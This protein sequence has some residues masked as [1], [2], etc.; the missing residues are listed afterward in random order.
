V[1]ASTSTATG[2]AGDIVVLLGEA[3]VSEGDPP[4]HEIPEYVEKY[5]PRLEYNRWSPE[6]FSADYSVPI[7]IHL[8]HV[9]GH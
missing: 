8:T 4:A 2:R 6:D 9:R 1:S 5:E 3:A 7:R